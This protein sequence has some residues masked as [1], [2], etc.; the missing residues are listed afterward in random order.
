MCVEKIQMMF[1][2]FRRNAMF[3]LITIFRNSEKKKKPN[4]VY[5]PDWSICL[6]SFCFFRYFDFAQYDKKNKKASSESRTEHE[7]K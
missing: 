6:S 4:E 5:S 7:R 2:A 1:W 3:F